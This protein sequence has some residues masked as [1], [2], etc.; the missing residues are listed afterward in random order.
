M[1][2]KAVLGVVL[3]V[4]AATLAGGG[5]YAA[6]MTKQ[7]KV[8][9][10]TFCPLTG[11]K[12]ATLIIIDKTDPLTAAEQARARD[13]IAAARTSVA[14]GDRITIKLLHERKNTNDVVLDTVADLCNPGAEANPLFENPR[15][16]AA[17][18]Q[19]AFIEPIDSALENVAGLGSAPASPI[20]QSIQS[21]LNGIPAGTTPI[22]KIILISDL[23]EHSPEGSAYTG[24]LNAATLR[25][26]LPKEVQR[27][28]K[29]AD[30]RVLLLP[31]PKY[32]SQQAAAV[33]VWATFFKEA[34][35]HAAE[36]MGP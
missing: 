6:R 25:K 34:T 18:Y 14:R 11:S 28:L 2:W 33:K 10:E 16:V 19:Q 1:T 36:I 24:T 21:A 27:A 12:T 32:A 13:A 22:L 15:R 3:M 17:R 9:L 20:A 4:L 23:M 31:R 5:F 8:D 7:D 26:I 30:I 35:G 29:N